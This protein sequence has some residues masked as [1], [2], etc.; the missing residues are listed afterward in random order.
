MTRIDA[1]PPIV[2]A[3][4]GSLVQRA[5]RFIFGAP[6]PITPGER[7]NPQVDALLLHRLPFELRAQIWN[8]YFHS[9]VTKLVHITSYA[10][11]AAECVAQDWQNF[12]PRS[13]LK[14]SQLKEKRN[15]LNVLLNCKRM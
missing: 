6:K 11:T 13:H 3:N 4:R 1:L 10:I 7:D 15:R 8:A 14:C 2:S 5:K 12:S 9:A